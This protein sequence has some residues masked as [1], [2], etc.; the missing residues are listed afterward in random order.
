MNATALWK[1]LVKNLLL[2]NLDSIVTGDKT[3]AAEAGFG[4]APSTFTY[5]F[6][7]RTDRDYGEVVSVWR[8]LGP[9]SS[10]SD[11]GLCPFDTGGLWHRRFCPTATRAEVVAIFNVHTGPLSGHPQRVAAALARDYHSVGDY[12]DGLP[13][14]I[15]APEL[16]LCSPTDPRA[17][18]WE[19][20]LKKDAATN[21]LVE[22]T[23]IFWKPGAADQFSDWLME[24]LGGTPNDQMRDLLEWCRNNALE[25]PLPSE[26]TRAYL[27]E[28]VSV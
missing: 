6:V 25:V 19:S 7:G 20:R 16:N 11:G 5:W 8:P 24:D 17:W 28:V 4:L 13:P 18:T 10:G 9:L 27:H 23:R 22:P 15:G 14:S 21:G 1:P 26:A 3:R 2:G 12:I